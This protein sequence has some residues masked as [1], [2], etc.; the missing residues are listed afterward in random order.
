MFCSFCPPSTYGDFN[1]IGSRPT[2]TRPDPED[3]M[4]PSIRELIG[5]LE[6]G[7]DLGQINRSLLPEGERAC[8]NRCAAVRAFDAD[9]VEKV[10][11]PAIPDDEDRRFPFE[12][13]IRREVVEP[14]PR[15]R[16][17]YR[18]RDGAR[19]EHF[20]A[21][22]QDEGG[23]GQGEPTLPRAIEDLSRALVAYYRGLAPEP[24]L[25]VLYHLVAADRAEARALFRRLYDE[26]DAR[27]DL[28]CCADL[29]GTLE[30]RGPI[31]G[32]ELKADLDDTSAYLKTRSLWATEYY[33][34][35]Q[36][37]ER[38][39]PGREFRDFLDDASRWIL[40][41]YA[42]G[43]MGKTMFLRW[44]L[45]RKCVPGRFP[46]ARIDFDFV[47]PVAA[48]QE[49]WLLL[50]EVADQLNSQFPRNPFREMLDE[51]NEYRLILG[52]RGLAMPS[53]RPSEARPPGD[54]SREHL[55]RNVPER[56]L[57]VLRDLKLARPVVVLFDT[58]EDVVL[59]QPDRLLALLDLVDG[60][61]RDHEDIR[62]V[63]AG[64][65]DLREKVE[66]FAARFGAR[67]R[68]L[69]MSPFSDD[70]ARGYLEEK[71]GLSPALP[72]A[73]VISK[74]GGNPFK[75]ALYAD[76]LRAHPETPGDE[77]LDYPDA[78]L[79]YLIKRII[80]RIDDPHLHWLLRYGVI[81]RR[82]TRAYLEAVMVGR[83]KEAMAGA[84]PSD[85]PGRDPVP[86]AKKK[87]LFRTDL[88]AS[89]QT[90]DWSELW[91]KL[92]QYASPQYAWVSQVGN[93]RDTVVFHGDVVNPMR[94]L[95]RKH[96]PEAFERPAPRRPRLFR[97]QDRRRS[98]AL[99]RSRA[100]RRLP[101]FPAR[102][103]LGPRLLA[104]GAARRGGA[105]Q[106]ALAER[107]GGGGA[108][109]RVRGPHRRRGPRVG[110]LRDGAGEG[111]AGP[112]GAR[113]GVGPALGPGR[114]RPACRGGGRD[115][116]G[117]AGH[118]RGRA[119]AV[120]RPHPHPAGRLPGRARPRDA[121]TGVPPGDRA[122]A[123][124]RAAEDRGADPR[125]AGPLRGSGR[126]IQGRR[127]PG[128]P[129]RVL[130]HC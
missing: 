113:A 72:L 115:G 16:G 120:A 85:D 68:S 7:E 49:P 24:A 66:G 36:Y 15:A 129:V 109:R 42:T 23:L 30:G 99:G 51:F 35:I 73:E 6:Q 124:D 118:P 54:V 105:G 56:F 80:D 116:P 53:G 128:G 130:P 110:P 111:G 59:N 86:E 95:L 107:P 65:Y 97:G 101:P 39:V 55:K 75:L 5:R 43:G 28:A 25:E 84:W 27:F 17:M 125:H 81:P 13:L 126:R 4:K 76:L 20:Q 114:R 98:R 127:G 41:V 102:R 82:L 74:S 26:A 93:D 77:I 33:Q 92:A 69:P 47:D 112:P 9:M 29:V 46:C 90:L 122:R 104:R 119:G 40:Q 50:L 62:L 2:P 34:T 78:D 123:R 1:G 100:R 89:A 3:P 22:V 79:A 52:R 91:M 45:A 58:L 121:E 60:L 14:V 87:V 106:P 117:P 44:A 10:L 64:R 61:H 83:L 38:P 71:R 8:S 57:A 103:G 21:W 108:R 96:Q 12:E 31:L 48:T 70:E 32:R 94:R 37:Y 67:T 18:L 63:L 88:G 19:R 11:R